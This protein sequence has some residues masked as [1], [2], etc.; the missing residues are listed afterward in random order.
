M[1][2]YRKRTNGTSRGN[3]ST[4]NSLNGVN[5]GLNIAEEKIELNGSNRNYLK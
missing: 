2:I 1:K 3:I 4:E 5:S